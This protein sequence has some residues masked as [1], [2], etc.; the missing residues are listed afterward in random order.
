MLD[1][2]RADGAELDPDGAADTIATIAAANIEEGTSMLF[3]TR[4]GRP[5]EHD[6]IHGAA[7]RKAAEHGIDVPAITLMHAL[8]EHRH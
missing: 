7:I 5:T 8:L 2:R 4:A 3:D 1:H 6:A